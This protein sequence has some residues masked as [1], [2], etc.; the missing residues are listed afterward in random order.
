MVDTKD[1]KAEGFTLESVHRSP[2][3]SKHPIKSHNF[4]LGLIKDSEIK[5][6]K[7][8]KTSTKPVPEEIKYYKQNLI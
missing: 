4:N 8:F 7:Y 5:V 3:Q 1:L 2:R 6:I